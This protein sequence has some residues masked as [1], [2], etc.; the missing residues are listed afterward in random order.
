MVDI[1]N[2]DDWNFDGLHNGVMFQ[3][4][5][6]RNLLAFIMWEL[7][8]YTIFQLIYAQLYHICKKNPKNNPPPKK[9]KKKKKT[10][11]QHDCLHANKNTSLTV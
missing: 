11:K 7:P 8:Q 3:V 5:Y 10:N 6:H 9:K 2:I 4:I 1:Y